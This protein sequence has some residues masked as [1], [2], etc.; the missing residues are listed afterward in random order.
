MLRTRQTAVL[1]VWTELIGWLILSD[2]R[3]NV[4]KTP[5][6]RQVSR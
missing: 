5:L 6:C 2:L 1:N 3:V 4:G